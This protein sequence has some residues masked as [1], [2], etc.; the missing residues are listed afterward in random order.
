MGVSKPNTDSAPKGVRTACH[1]VL[2]EVGV[3]VATP[4]FEAVP[5]KVAMRLAT[6]R[7]NSSGGT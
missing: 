7:S 1:S 4:F 6:N 5:P 2:E 3:I